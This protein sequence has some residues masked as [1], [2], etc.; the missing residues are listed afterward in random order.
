MKSSKDV[1]LEKSEPLTARE[2]NLFGS[3]GVGAKILPPFR[4]LN[5]Q[6]IFIGDYVSIRE[7]C[8]LHAYEDLTKLHEFIAHQYKKDFDLSRYRY[9]SRIEIDREVQIGRNFFISC[10]NSVRIERNVTISERVFIGDNNHSFS[11]PEVPIMQQPNKVGTPIIV[12]RGSWI[13]AG[14]SVL[15]GARLG[16]NSVVGTLSVVKDEFADHAVI[17]PEPARLLYIKQHRASRPRNARSN[18]SSKRSSGMR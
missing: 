1:L 12:G 14:A 2:K 13:G 6:R 7:G 9:D 10:T 17:G 4:I 15:G 11:H 3:F 18:P 16:R 8:Y 5:P